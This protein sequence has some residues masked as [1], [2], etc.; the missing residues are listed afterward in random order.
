[1]KPHGK[2]LIASLSLLIAQAAMLT[3][4]SP[5]AATDLV[6]FELPW[7]KGVAH[8]VGGYL[9]N[10]GTHINIDKYAID[11]DLKTETT[12]SAKAGTVVALKRGVTGCSASGAY[13]NFVEI[14]HGGGVKSLYA[15]LGAVGVMLRQKVVTGADIGTSGL[16]GNT[17]P[18]PPGAAHLHFRVT[19]SGAAHKPEPMGGYTSFAK[20]P[21]YTSNNEFDLNWHIRSTNTTGAA[22]STVTSGRTGIPVAGD[23]DGQGGDNPGVV[24]GNLWQFATQAATINYGNP[25]DIPIAGD[26][27]GDGYASVGVVRGNTWLLSNDRIGSENGLAEIACAFGK[28]SDYFVVGDWDGDGKDTPAVVRG[29]TWYFMQTK[30]PGNTCADATTTSVAFGTATDT[31]IVTNW[32]RG[33]IGGDAADDIGIIRGNGWYLDR[34]NGG[35][36]EIQFTYGDILDVPIPGDW[37]GDGVDTPSVVRIA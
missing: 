11:W 26:W 13:G 36:A 34:G 29:N 17:K 6:G 14:N 21:S 15:H 33:Q 18:C 37:N 16:T 10:E 22:T 1:M 35:G 31:P 28:V 30:Y 7:R 3:G 24:R 12:L 4:A 23:W 32:D 5:A 2:R 25:D 27:N 20:G 9:Y 19:K 8:K